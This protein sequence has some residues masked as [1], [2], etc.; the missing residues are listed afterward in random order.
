MALEMMAP[1]VHREL[2]KVTTGPLHCGGAISATY[3]AAADRAIA[4]PNPVQN[5]PAI[6]AW[7]FLAVH[8]TIPPNITTEAPADILHLRPC[9]SAAGPATKEPHMLPTV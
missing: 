4:T 1:T 3:E 8:R 2:Y 5:R 6:K 9:R 7:M